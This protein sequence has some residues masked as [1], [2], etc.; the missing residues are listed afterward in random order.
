MARRDR[1]CLP[2][3]QTACI[4]P[5]IAAA[6]AGSGGVADPGEASHPRGVARK[7]AGRAAKDFS[8]GEH[9]GAVRQLQGKE[10]VLLHQLNCGLPPPPL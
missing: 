3:G 1:N 10:G 7:L 9:I 6:V 8:I 5:I 2:H 4:L